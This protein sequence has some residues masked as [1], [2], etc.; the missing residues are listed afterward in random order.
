MSSEIENFNKQGVF[1]L[2][3]INNE[4]QDRT[5][6]PFVWSFKRK[7][8]P[9]GE[10]T[11]HKARLFT[12]GAKKTKGIGYWNSCT[13][14]VQSS[15]IYLALALHQMSDWQCRN[16]DYML[17]LTQHPTDT[18]AHLKIPAGHHVSDEDGN[19]VSNQHCL[20]LLK[21]CYGTKDAATN[22]FDALQKA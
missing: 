21:N 2:V 4:P 9:L 8:N 1:E 13:T 17:A 6:V 20:K 22:W 14:M 7:R 12:H 10:L 15:T 18:D 11:K 5:M 3:P 19:D 16:S